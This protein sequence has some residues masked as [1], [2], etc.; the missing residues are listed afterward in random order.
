MNTEASYESLFKEYQDDSAILR[1]EKYARWSLPTIFANP[2]LRSG[3]QVAVQ[4]DYQSVGA[5]LTNNLASKLASLLFPSNQSFF[6]LDSTVHSDTMSKELGVQTTELASAMAKLENDAYRRIFLR[7]SYHQIV[8]T[9]KLLITTGNALL[10]RDSADT[11]LHA[12]SLRQYSLL[13]DGSGKVLDMILKERTTREMLPEDKRTAFEG[14]KEYDALNLYTRI[15]RESRSVGDVYVVTQCVEHVKLDTADEYPEAICPYI[16]V[17]WNLVTGENY[18]RGLVEDYAGDFA[19]LSELSEALAL[20]EIEACRVLHLAAPGA[21]GDVDSM[22]EQDSGAWVS[23]D[24]GKVQAYEAGDYNK[25]VALSADLQQ[26]TQRLSPAFMYTG[27]TRD[28]ERVDIL[29][30]VKLH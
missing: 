29:A 23:A 14:R 10:Y 13:R 26:I 9:M 11:N 25:I 24:P 7:A 16:P 2:E 22:A 27:N 18:G 21:G 8:H 20:Y 6:R 4:R 30:L 3:K 28:A 15:K 5:M 1:M 17:C 12:Y 19:K